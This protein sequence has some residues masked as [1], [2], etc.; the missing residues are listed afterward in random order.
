MNKVLSSSLVFVL[1]VCACGEF[2]QPTESIGDVN[3]VR[4]VPKTYHAPNIAFEEG[5]YTVGAGASE[6]LGFAEVDRTVDGQVT[7]FGVHPIDLV[8]GSAIRLVGWSDAWASYYV[9][10]PTDLRGARRLVA[11]QEMSD[12]VK[13]GLERRYFDFTADTT[14]EYLLVV[15]PINTPAIE[16]VMLPQCVGGPCAE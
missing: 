7:D 15:G 1:F 8:D 14:G 9:Y 10:S 11:S 3:R 16:Y 6:L 2:D 13:D 4:V 12:P 5:G